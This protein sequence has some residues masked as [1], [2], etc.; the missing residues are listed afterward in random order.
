MES[1]RSF[2][3]LGTV[4]LIATVCGAACSLYFV[5]NAGSNNNSVVLKSLF[6][7]WIL[8]PFIAFFIMLSIV[9][10]WKTGIQNVIHWLLIILTIVSLIGYSGLIKIPNTKNAFVFLI[11][12]FLSWVLLIATV[13][14]ARKFSKFNK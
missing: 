13:I 8:S 12:P 1:K 6:I 9:R 4:A 5:I 10:K 2:I 7:V 3:T 14:A 11:I